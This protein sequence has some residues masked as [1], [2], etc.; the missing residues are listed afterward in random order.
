MTASF[1]RQKVLLVEPSFH[2]DRQEG[3]PSFGLLQIAGVLQKSGFDVNVWVDPGLPTPS[4]IE[5]LSFVGFTATTANYGEAERLANQIKGQ[6]PNLP[7][8]LGGVHS[9]VFQQ[10]L[11]GLESPWDFVI[12]GEGENIA[13]NI[14]QGREQ[15]GLVMG[16]FLSRHELD[17]LPLPAFDAVFP[18]HKDRFVRFGDEKPT[19]PYFTGRGCP[20]A[21]T[22]CT[23][24]VT[25]RGIRYKNTDKVLDELRFIKNKFGV[26]SF[27][28]YDDTFTVKPARVETLVDGFGRLG[29]DWM[30][31]A[32]ADSDLPQKLWSEMKESG[33]R[34]VSIGA[35]SA[36]SDV[37]KYYGKKITLDMIRQQVSRLREAR[38]PSRLYFMFGAPEDSLQTAEEMKK[39]IMDERPTNVRLSWLTPMPGSKIWQNTY[40]RMQY[41]EIRRLIDQ[42]F[43]LSTPSNMKPLF[44][45]TNHL[46]PLELRRTYE[47]LF[48]FCENW[49]RAHAA[50]HSI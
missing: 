46:N 33:C 2:N 37:L 31:N 5:G 11:L 8:A 35:E 50:E 41:E 40:G 1:E 47:E 45:H 43:Y 6:R 24:D 29:M 32:R 28:F 39:F 4:D 15:N 16:K 27:V 13:D 36:S 49:N 48:D 7:V 42:T 21:C 10:H 22:F 23:T 30:C 26:S 25:G 3:P 20:Y 17:N 9:T 14:A 34:L 18:S 44:D 12:A 19:F 38:L